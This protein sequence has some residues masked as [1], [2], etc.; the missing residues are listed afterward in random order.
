MKKI[1]IQI[2]IGL[3][4][5][6]A[7][8]ILSATGYLSYRNLSSIV[9][10][11]QVDLKPDH[12]LLSI[13]E[14]S[15]DLEKAQ[16]SIRIYTNTLNTQDLKPYYAIISKIDEKVSRLRSE[17]LNDSVLLIQ[18]DTISKLI[19]RNIVIWNQLLYLHNNQTVVEDIKNLSVRLDSSSRAGPKD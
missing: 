5:I 1:S 18:T 3:L 4:M 16:N 8:V 9:A 17:C 13:R 7:V 19:D 2:K 15:M 12:R 6:M 10:S 11:I 14:I